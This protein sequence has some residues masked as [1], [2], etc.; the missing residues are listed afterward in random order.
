MT[1]WLARQ[2]ELTLAII[3]VLL[4]IAPILI[5]VPGL[6]WWERRLLSWM[7]DRIG[8]NRVPTMTNAK[9][10]KYRAA[11]LVQTLFDGLKLFL[12]EDITPASVDRKIYFFAPALALFP[13]FV[14]GGTMPFRSPASGNTSLPSPTSRSVSCSCSRSPR[15][16]CTASCS[17]ATQA[18][19][20]I[21]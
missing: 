15:S 8:P 4:L 17:L 10:R 18:T 20:S 9:G 3:R 2:S 19:T 6:I 21:H 12:K 5:L 13:A 7:Q 11:G 1:E 16:A 14:L